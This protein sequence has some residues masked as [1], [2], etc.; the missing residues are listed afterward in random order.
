MPTA[1]SRAHCALS[2]P[3]GASAQR[4]D[5]TALWAVGAQP[6][7]GS[8]AT[9]LPCRLG[10]LTAPSFRCRGT[11]LWRKMTDPPRKKMVKDLVFLSLLSFSFLGV[12]SRVPQGALARVGGTPPSG[13]RV[14]FLMEQQSPW[15]AQRPPSSFWAQSQ[16]CLEQGATGDTAVLHLHRTGPEASPAT[17][18]ASPPAV[19]VQPSPPGLLSQPPSC[20]A[21]EGLLGCRFGFALA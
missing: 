3:A 8:R 14:V 5:C 7:H 13:G 17:P 15:G 20:T 18:V 11:M 1:A 19:A 2:R 6:P 12:L 16:G 21:E 9:V 4:T 10:T